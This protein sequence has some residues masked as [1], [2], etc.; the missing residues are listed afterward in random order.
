[1]SKSAAA[2][3]G[4]EVQITVN[5]VIFDGIFPGPPPRI[6][7]HVVATRPDG[8]RRAV[9]SAERVEDPEILKAAEAARKGDTVRLTVA[10]Q[11]NPMD[12]WVTGFEVVSAASTV[13]SAEA[14]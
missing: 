3:K 12:S 5:T 6:R 9:S 7:T 2:E 11:W 1:M 8:Q 10:T 4:T 13:A 14:A